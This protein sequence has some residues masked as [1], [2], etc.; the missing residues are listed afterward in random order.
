V[1][2]PES[3]T[4]TYAVASNCTA[5]NTFT[6]GGGI[7]FVVTPT[8]LLAGGAARRRDRGWIRREA[9]LPDLHQCRS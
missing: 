5:T 8:G 6:I 9:G 4:G 2:T 7:S 3:F 1:I